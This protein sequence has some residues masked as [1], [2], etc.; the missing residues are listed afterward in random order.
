MARLHK[1]NHGKG[2]TDTPIAIQHSGGIRTSIDASSQEGKYI[3]QTA[4]QFE[5]FFPTFEAT[6]FL[7]CCFKED[8]NK[9]HTLLTFL[10]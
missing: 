7:I 5:Y 4:M 10:N 8:E 1:L 2:W 6:E 9:D 3:S